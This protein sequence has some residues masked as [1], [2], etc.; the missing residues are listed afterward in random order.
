MIQVA[1]NLTFEEYLTYDDGTD[2]LYELIDGELVMVPLPTADHS[3]V[4]DLLS[5]IF[6]AEIEKLGLNWIVKRD[7]G[8]YVGTNPETGKD[9][10]RT[11]DLC[12]ITSEQWNEV[13][14]N[15]KAAAVL[16]TPPLLIVEV[17]SPGSK[18]TDYKEKESEYKNAGV[19][20]YWIID[21]PKSKVTVLSLINGEYQSTEF[22]SN[23][24][25]TS[26]IFPQLVL[27]AQK[28]LSV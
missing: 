22:T 10:S 11:P 26:Q 12:V 7:V 17:V 14:A 24:L 16:K 2:N 19:R 4:I 21:L 20:E 3:D 9:R 8:T 28:V 23:Q 5:K 15:K 1:T 25:I 27:T 13:K 6:W 18:K